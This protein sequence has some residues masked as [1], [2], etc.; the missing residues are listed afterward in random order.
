MFI[1]R[2]DSIIGIIVIIITKKKKS[3]FMG[4]Y[5]VM[6]TTLAY[7]AVVIF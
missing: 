2:K 5:T 6:M 3:I 4:S 1:H 7:V